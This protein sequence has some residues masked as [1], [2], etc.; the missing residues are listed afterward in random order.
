MQIVDCL[1][2]ELSIEGAISL[3]SYPIIVLF[4]DQAAKEFTDIRLQSH[5]L[6]VLKSL[7]AAP[8]RPST[9]AGNAFQFLSGLLCHAC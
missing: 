4:D 2:V 8:Q 7:S 6:T 9:V 5:I 1:C 3:L